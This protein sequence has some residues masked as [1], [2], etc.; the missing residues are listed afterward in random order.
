MSKIIPFENEID[1]FFK[2]VGQGLELVLK[3]HN[4]R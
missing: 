4:G 2:E 1:R 3:S